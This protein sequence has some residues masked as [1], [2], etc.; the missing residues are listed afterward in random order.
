MTAGEVLKLTGQLN[1]RRVL[2]APLQQGP[3]IHFVKSIPGTGSASCLTMPWLQYFRHLRL[4][5]LERIV[6]SSNGWPG[7]DIAIGL[8]RHS[9]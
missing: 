3:S 5:V 6:G 4:F 8:A 1:S 2:V 9:R 7:Y